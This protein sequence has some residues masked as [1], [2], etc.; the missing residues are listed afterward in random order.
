MASP[1]GISIDVLRKT[2]NGILDFIERDL[3]I[4]DV[5]LKQNYY[6]SVTNDTLYSM[7]HPPKELA[8]GSLMDDW[9]FVLSASKGA[10]QQLP[11]MFIH[12]APLLQ[13]L[14]QGVPNYISPEGPQKKEVT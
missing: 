7:D 5:D 6:W 13:A 14:S 11:I 12:I 10:D 8:V 3:G 2:I 4:T 9:D 1:N